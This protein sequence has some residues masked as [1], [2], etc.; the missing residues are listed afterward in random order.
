M[1]AAFQLERDG[2]QWFLVTRVPLTLP[3]KVRISTNQPPV[4][5]FTAREKQVFDLACQGK[6]N[7]EIAAALAIDVRT[8]KFHVSAVL[9]K[10][11][12]ESRFELYQRFGGT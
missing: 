8:V 10:T 12:C 4:L 7:K 1:R 5:T 11:C 2:K 9:R 3:E 6:Q